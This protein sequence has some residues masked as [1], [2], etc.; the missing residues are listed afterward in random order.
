[1]GEKGRRGVRGFLPS[2]R[3]CLFGISYF[4]HFLYIHKY[5]KLQGGYEKS[6][7][8]TPLQMTSFVSY[9]HPAFHFSPDG[10]HCRYS[11]FCIEIRDYRL[12]RNKRGDYD[13]FYK[14]NMKTKIVPYCILRNKRLLKLESLFRTDFSKIFFFNSLLIT[15]NLFDTDKKRC[16]FF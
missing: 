5:E 15:Q 13:F 16:E 8:L 10:F 14:I 6:S 1:M 3:P 11:I 2:I 4:N 9:L 12:Q 7:M